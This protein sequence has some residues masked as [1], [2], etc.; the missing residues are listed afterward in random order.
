MYMGM[1][2]FGI[3]ATQENP[4]VHFI[5]PFF[6]EGIN[7][8]K[9]V[10]KEGLRRNENPLIISHIFYPKFIVNLQFLEER[11]PTVHFLEERKPTNYFLEKESPLSPLIGVSKAGYEEDFP[12]LS[13]SISNMP[14][15]K[16]RTRIDLGTHCEQKLEKLVDNIARES[17]PLTSY[18]NEKK[19]VKIVN[20]CREMGSSPGGFYRPGYDDGAKLRLYMMCPSLDWN[21]NTRKY[22]ERWH[23]QLMVALLCYRDILKKFICIL[24][25]I[26]LHKDDEHT[27]EEDE[28]LITKEEREDELAALQ[29]EI[30]LPLEE[31]LK[32]CA[33]K[34]GKALMSP[35]G[36]SFHLQLKEFL[37]ELSFWYPFFYTWYHD[38]NLDHMNS[39]L[40]IS[41]MALYFV[42]TCIELLE[43]FEDLGDLT[44]FNFYMQLLISCNLVKVKETS[45]KLKEASET[46]HQVEVS[47]S[48]K[49]THAKLAKDFQADF[50]VAERETAYTPFLPQAAFM[51]VAILEEAA[52]VKNENK[53]EW[54]IDLASVNMKEKFKASVI[55]Y[56]HPKAS[57]DFYMKVNE[58]NE[59][60]AA[61]DVLAGE[62]ENMLLLSQKLITPISEDV[63]VEKLQELGYS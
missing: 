41:R 51:L 8:E 43:L 46:D 44:S 7:L 57:K 47:A 62:Q 19:R 40:P 32:Y 37:V 22:G 45:A 59:T 36:G 31:I 48:K 9:Q 3:I 17:N 26:C 50:Q 21:P 49:I 52:K 25:S 6:S 1:G 35:H 29:S 30:D 58:D 60:D 39:V 18:V 12:S 33:A 24:Y 61:M 14:E 38:A 13:D 10:G 16:R 5:S 4:S 11:K 42:P 53:V 54:G 63:L 56:N 28:A 23:D 2:G 27:I 20:R 55:V 15:S 34:E